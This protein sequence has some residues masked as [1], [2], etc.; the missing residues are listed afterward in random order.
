MVS[1][2]GFDVEYGPDV[3]PSRV[4]LNLAV[5]TVREHLRQQVRDRAS[6]AFLLAY[7]GHQLGDRALIEEGLTAWAEAAGDDPLLT[8]VMMVWL[9]GGSFPSDP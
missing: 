5:R 9:E 8:V 7:L 1:K 2:L 3:L 6:N 4:R